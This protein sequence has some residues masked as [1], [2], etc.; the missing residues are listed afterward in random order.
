[1]CLSAVPGADAALIDTRL[2]R[3]SGLSRVAA[4]ATERS[5]ILARSESILVRCA[6]RTDM[7][8]GGDRIIRPC[9]SIVYTAVESVAESF[10]VVAGP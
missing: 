3:G 10:G 2:G 1:M 5:A 9:Q 7:A 6:R 8:V 4:A